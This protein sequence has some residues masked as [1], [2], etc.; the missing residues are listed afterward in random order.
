MS[1]VVGKD[2]IR[3]ER[4][5]KKSKKSQV[6]FLLVKSEAVWMNTWVKE[7]RKEIICS[8]ILCIYFNFALSLTWNLFTPSCFSCYD[9]VLVSLCAFQQV[10]SLQSRLMHSLWLLTACPTILLSSYVYIYDFPP[11]RF[12]EEQLSKGFSETEVIHL[13]SM[14][15]KIC[16]VK[17][18]RNSVVM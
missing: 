16:I 17:T 3:R 4:E 15:L 18:F 12:P 6:C 7:K 1:L 5:V 8:D 10:Q 11:D 13:H 2:K 14:W 9:C